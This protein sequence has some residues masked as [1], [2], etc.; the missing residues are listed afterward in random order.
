MKH[1]ISLFNSPLWAQ[2]HTDI[3]NEKL[4]RY[5]DKYRTINPKGRNRSGVNYQSFFLDLQTPELQDLLKTMLVNLNYCYK[6]MGGK[7]D[8]YTPTI[9]TGWFNICDKGDFNWPHVHDGYLS[10]VYYIDADEDTGKLSFKHP[11]TNIDNEWNDEWFDK[12][13]TT[14]ALSWS[15]VP[16]TGRCF[17]F[18]SWLEHKVHPNK[19][20]KTRISIA[21]NTTLSLKS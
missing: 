15:E 6:E 4:L 12:L 21:L 7:T 3:D 11:S 14:T 10:I 17:I 2:D 8:T 5:I 9:H 20:D 19:T 1:F 16:K 13:S 18:P